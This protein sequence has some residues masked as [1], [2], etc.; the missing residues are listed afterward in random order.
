MA[1]GTIEQPGMIATDF[2]PWLRLGLRP[3]KRH[4]NQRVSSRF[5]A[6]VAQRGSGG[7][8]RLKGLIEFKTAM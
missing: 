4:E 5:R 1:P 6:R 2:R 3:A 7:L 8:M